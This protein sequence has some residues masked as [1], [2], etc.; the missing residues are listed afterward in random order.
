MVIVFRV[1]V[2]KLRDFRN[3]IRNILVVTNVAVRGIDIAS[4]NYVV[5][6]DLPTDIEEYVHRVG[7]TGCVGNVGKSISFFDQERDGPNAGKFVSFLTKSNADVPPFMQAMVSGVSGMGYDFSAPS[8]QGAL[9]VE[10]C[11]EQV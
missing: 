10:I 4:V 7:R 5:N 2:S 11:A 8:T 9:L 3:G 1:S 6:Y